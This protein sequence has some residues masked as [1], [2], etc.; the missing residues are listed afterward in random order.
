MGHAPRG[1][2]HVVLVD[3]ADDPNGWTTPVPYNLI[4]LTAVSADRRIVDRQHDD[5]LRMVFTHEYAHVL[6][7]DQAR[8]WATPRARRLR[9]RVPFAFPNL[10]LPR[11]ADRGHRH[12][13][14]ESRR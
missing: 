1:R 6:H 14:G 12:V 3:Q 13:R 8:G 2:T 10:T 9:P 4:E 11:V 5:W 7:L